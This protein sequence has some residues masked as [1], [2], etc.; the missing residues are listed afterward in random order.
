MGGSNTQ[1]ILGNALVA[2]GVSCEQGDWIC[3]KPYWPGSI[4]DKCSRHDRRL[5]TCLA[6]PPRPVNPEV[7]ARPVLGP[8]L[9]PWRTQGNTRCQAD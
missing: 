7:V 9:A 8:F 2:A 5:L 6:A 4:Q 1:F 3:E